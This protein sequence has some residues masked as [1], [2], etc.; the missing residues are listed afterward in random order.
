MD[1]EFAELYY[2]LG[3]RF[4]KKSEVSLALVYLKRA[5][6]CG[7]STPEAFNV[8][9]LCYYKS[10]NLVQSVNAFKKS[11]DI[12]NEDNLAGVYLDSLGEVFGDVQTLMLEIKTYIEKKEYIKAAIVYKAK[13]LDKGFINE[14]IFNFVG[15][16]YALGGRL[17]VARKYWK[18][19]LYVDPKNHDA[20]YYLA[21]TH[22]LKRVFG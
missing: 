17:F 10:G 2:N 11:I 13:I 22:W 18:K 20:L 19:T 9:G 7:Y 3:L 8:M 6:G 12:K 14:N 4:A 15:V 16:L 1:N 5:I 21:Q